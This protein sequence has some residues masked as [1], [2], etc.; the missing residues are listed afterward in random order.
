M[1][2][3][4]RVL[5]ML[6]F[7]LPLAAACSAEIDSPEDVATMGSEIQRHDGR[8]PL[9]CPFELGDCDGKR[10]NGCET[11][12]LFDSRNC[13]ACD[14]VCGAGSICEDGACLEL[15]EPNLA[16]CDGDT[17]NFCETDVSSDPENC[18]DCGVVCRGNR[19]CVDGQCRAQHPRH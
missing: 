1:K 17:N 2:S 8:P 14:L 19:I 6:G 11:P 5:G 10:K 13:G 15:C 12:L 3:K 4:R 16:D 7:F 9:E 18:G